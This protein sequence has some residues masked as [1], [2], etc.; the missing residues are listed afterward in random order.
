MTAADGKAPVRLPGRVRLGLIGDNIRRS[1][2]PDLHRLAGQLTGLDVSYDLF[3][4]RDMGKHFDQVFEACRA[5]GL[6]GVNVTYPCKQDVIPLLHDLSEDARVLNAVNTVVLRNGRRIGHNTDLF[7][8]AESF[9]R[10]LPDV[11]RRLVV[12]FGAGG[13]SRMSTTSSPPCPRSPSS[14]SR[15]ASRT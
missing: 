8:F 15:W 12:Q 11:A 5:A 4:P 1:R 3:I 2:S 9:R 7:G 10:N 13:A 6:R 14:P